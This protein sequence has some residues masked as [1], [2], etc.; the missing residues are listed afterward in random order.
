MKKIA[1][2]FVL[3]CFLFTIA[4]DEKKTIESIRLGDTVSNTTL[5]TLHTSLAAL[6][7]MGKISDENWAKIEK[8][9]GTY[10]AARK[11]LLDLLDTWEAGV[12]KPPLERIMIAF[13]NMNRIIVDI[14]ELIDSLGVKR[15]TWIQRKL[16][17]AEVMAQ[18]YYESK[19]R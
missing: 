13:A 18:A 10:E 12:N 11:T 17:D 4:C 3:I 8:I 19:M 5:I 1:V 2:F 6:H 15:L 14:K 7:A 16:L 9:W